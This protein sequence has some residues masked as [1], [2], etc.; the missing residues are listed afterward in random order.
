[1]YC[2]KCGIKNLEDARFC[3]SCGANIELVPRALE[4]RLDAAAEGV[5]EVEGHE[6]KGRKERKH[7]IKEPPTLEKG[8][9]N[10]FGGVAFFIIVALGFFYLI[11]AFWLWIWFIIPALEHVGKGIGQIIR[12]R[13]ARHA[14]A[15]TAGYA[16]APPQAATA[17]ALPAPDTSEILRPPASVTESTTRDLVAHRKDF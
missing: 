1:M 7:K 8:I 11:G 14:L 4:G 2:P 17:H 16:E 10:I 6:K 3:R 5:L 13:Q 12:S 15:P 9:E